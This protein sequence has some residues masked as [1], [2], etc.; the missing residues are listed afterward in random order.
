V[1][2]RDFIL[3]VHRCCHALRALPVPVIAR[4]QGYAL[5][6]GMEIAA[7]CDLRVAAEGA[8]FG[9][10]EVKLGIPSVVEAALLPGLMGWGK[11]REILFLGETFSVAQAASWGL[12]ERVV[13]EASLDAAVEEWI[14]ALLRNGPRAVRLQKKLV[15]DWETLPLDAAIDAG[16]DAFVAAWETD[17]PRRA[18]AE[19]LAARRARRG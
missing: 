1:S 4:I 18:M 17:E 6:A 2:A 19:F 9:M 16:V 15:R 7:S 8:V 13:P 10:P 12:V 3:H 5:G 14:A 11:A